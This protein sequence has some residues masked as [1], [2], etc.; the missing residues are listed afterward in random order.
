MSKLHGHARH[1]PPVSSVPPALRGHEGRFLVPAGKGMLPSALVAGSCSAAALLPS[2]KRLPDCR[3]GLRPNL[4]CSA[5]YPSAYGSFLSFSCRAI[6]APSF[7]M[8]RPF[9]SISPLF[10]S[11]RDAPPAENRRISPGCRF[12]RFVI[13]TPVQ[14]GSPAQGSNITCAPW[15]GIALKPAGA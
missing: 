12:C 7:V 8:T 9:S 13:R 1:N 2:P 5:A 14:T 11:V 6:T 10:F 15:H 3:M 4:D